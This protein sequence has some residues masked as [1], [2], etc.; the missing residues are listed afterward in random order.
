MVIG[1]MMM[2]KWTMILDNVDMV[3]RISIA[4]TRLLHMRLV[5]W[6]VSRGLLPE[7]REEVTLSACFSYPATTLKRSY[8]NRHSQLLINKR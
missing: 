1:I 5:W 6:C 3:E 4:E 7:V 8:N 2:I